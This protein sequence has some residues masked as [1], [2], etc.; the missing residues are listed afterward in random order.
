MTSATRKRV[1]IPRTTR[2]R[3]VLVDAIYGAVGVSV[4]VAASAAGI[5]VAERLGHM[6]SRKGMS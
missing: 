6:K 4:L 1:V 3:V 5:P 2:L